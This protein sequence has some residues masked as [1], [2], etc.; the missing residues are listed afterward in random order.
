MAPESLSK[1]EN[2]QRI[3]NSN[4][5]FIDP[6]DLAFKNSIFKLESVNPFLENKVIA[7][8][9]EGIEKCLNFLINYVFFL[10]FEGKKLIF[11]DHEIGPKMDF[12][13]N[14]LEKF[15]TDT[16][17]EKG[18]FKFFSFKMDKQSLAS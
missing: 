10:N 13:K 18:T 12:Y 4:D 2:W 9:N 6:L 16:K 14:K 15:A 8:H 7:Y 1:I 17:D 5:E 3:S 11:K